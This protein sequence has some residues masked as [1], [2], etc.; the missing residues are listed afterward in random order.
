MDDGV[1]EGGPQNQAGGVNNTFNSDGTNSIT[2]GTNATPVNWYSVAP[3]VGV[4]ALYTITFTDAGTGTG[5]AT[6]I[7]NNGVAL[8]L[9]V[10]QF[11]AA[12]GG[13]GSRNFTY[14][15]K[16]AAGTTVAS[17]TGNVNNTI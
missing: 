12:T 13:I 1:G 11:P 6:G 14:A 10:S 4:G 2:T 17:G 5:T 8:S 15:I 3:Q 16:N 7:T 9:A